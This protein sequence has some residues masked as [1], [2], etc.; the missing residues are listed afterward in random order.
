VTWHSL[1]L[2]PVP[3]SRAR[4]ACT[5]FSI[6]QKS[7]EPVLN[8]RRYRSCSG[9]A[10]ELLLMASR[11]S[12]L[13]SLYI[14]VL[15]SLVLLASVAPTS[16]YPVAGDLEASI[17]SRSKI[18]VWVFTHPHRYQMS[19]FGWRFS[20]TSIAALPLDGHEGAGVPRE[21][22]PKKPPITAG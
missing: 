21:P 6:L 20:S 22:F 15:Y 3:R 1:Q 5:S 13:V 18:V 8:Q 9:R 7:A 19:N 17:Q 4:C 10:R 2:A 12:D 11:F 14:A 16:W